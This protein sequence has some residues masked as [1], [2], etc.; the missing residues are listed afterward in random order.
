MIRAALFKLGSFQLYI[1]DAVV[2]ERALGL[3]S[4][5]KS[6]VKC[7]KPSVDITVKSNAIGHKKKL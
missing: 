6:S 3:P 2:G 4:T 7:M 5:G 1:L